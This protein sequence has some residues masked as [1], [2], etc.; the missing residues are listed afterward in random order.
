[1]SEG[2]K[3]ALAYFSEREIGD[4][5]N[6]GIPEILDAWG[7]PI[8]FIR[9]APG[10]GMKDLNNDGEYETQDVAAGYQDRD[11]PDP[12]D[13]RRMFAQAGTFALFPLVYS[14]GPDKLYEIY[15]PA[16]L[17]YRQTNPPN[18]PFLG[19]GA[20]AKA[21]PPVGCWQDAN[22]DRRDN[23]VDNIHNHL[24]IAGG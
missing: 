10:F 18:N 12:F 22:N 7:N 17:V 5:D 9:W 20:Y 15:D 1:M 2:D 24:L 6:D 19:V 8:K 11:A 3:T 23:S 14:A 13:P 16:N 4:R 21:G